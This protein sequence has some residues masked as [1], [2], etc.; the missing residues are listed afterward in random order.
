LAAQN[1]LVTWGEF[2]SALLLIF[3]DSAHGS[4]TWSHWEQTAAGPVSVF[5]CS[6]P[7]SASH[8]QI[9]TPVE[10]TRDNGGSGRW[11]AAGGVDSQDVISASKVLRSKPAYHGS[12]W[13]DPG[14]GTILRVS[15]IA[16]LKG[17]P[18]LESGATLVEYG[19]VH[20]K[21]QT[22]MCPMQSLPSLRHREVSR[23]CSEALQLRG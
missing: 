19:P 23:P 5:D 20:L 6:V 1:G 9:S 22:F 8:Y 7:K 14:S 13:I 4:T 10:E 15:L 17:N 18:T 3:N 21:D 2:G 16:D 11:W 12:L